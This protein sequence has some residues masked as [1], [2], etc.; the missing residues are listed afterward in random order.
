[1]RLWAPGFPEKLP[2]GLAPMALRPASRLGLRLTLLLCSVGLA[3]GCGTGIATVA[4]PQATPTVPVASALGPQLG[5]LWLVSSKTLRPI[6]G[7]PGAS[8]VGKSVVPAGAYINAA[9]S[10][11]ASLAVLQAADGSFDLMLLPTG[12]PVSLGLTL[13]TGAT[14]RLSP[15][16]TAA[17]AF[18]P[19]ATSAALITGLPASP[20]LQT[21]SAPAAIADAAVSDTGTVALESSRSLSILALKGVPVTIAAIAAPGGISFLPGSASSHDDLLFADSAANSLTL[22]RSTTSG[23]SAQTISTSGLLHSPSAVGVSSSGRWA[24]VANSGSQSAVRIDLSTLAASSVACTCQPTLVKPLA[25]DGAF[26]ITGLASG[27]NW[28]VNA[29]STTPGTL[30]I[31]ALPAT[32]NTAATSVVKP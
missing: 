8:Q 5:Y 7:I 22:A 1:M 32:P 27:P 17:L 10:A 25:D 30:F 24:L 20:S 31:P 19:G 6:L 12:T 26:R 21:I 16:A 14:I 2:A 4:A 29:A 9:T 3:T 23:P 15:S 13:P 28:L 18:T 11:T